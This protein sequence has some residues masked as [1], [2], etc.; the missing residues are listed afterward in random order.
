LVDQD[1]YLAQE[2]GCDV[3]TIV[4]TVRTAAD[5]II[6]NSDATHRLYHKQDRSF[7]L[8]NTVDVRRFD[9]AN[10]VEPGRLKVGIISS[11]LP[12]KGIEHF[13]ALAAL[14]SRRRPDL[15]FV[16][17]GP[18]TAYAETLAQSVRA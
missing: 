7:R 5:F 16:V 9:L 6:A 13:V 12:K 10:Q 18:R 15:E 14:A 11:N 4:Q 8:Y 1:A 17:F 2:F 3:S